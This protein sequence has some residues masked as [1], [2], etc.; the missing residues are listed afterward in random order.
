MKRTPTVRKHRTVGANSLPQNIPKPHKILPEFVPF[1]VPFAQD[2]RKF[3]GVFELFL[4]IHIMHEAPTN[5]GIKPFVGAL[6][7]LE[8]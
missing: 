6:L 7:E 2:L 1:R 8:T 4:E 3:R 5:G